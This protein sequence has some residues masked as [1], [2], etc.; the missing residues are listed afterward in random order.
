MHTKKELFELSIICESF[1]S[2][3]HILK[4]RVMLVCI[5]IECGT[6]KTKVIKKKKNRKNGIEISKAIKE[7]MKQRASCLK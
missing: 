3:P 4:R 6:T 7:L 2:C 1:K 5:S